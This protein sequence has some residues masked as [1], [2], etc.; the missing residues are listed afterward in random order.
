MQEIIEL[1]R[2]LIQFKTMHSQPQEIKRCAAFIEN[3]LKMLD[4]DYKRL[5]Y[6]NTPCVLV[7]PQDGFAPVLLMSHMDVVDAPGELFVPLE[8]DHRL[9]GR[10]SLDDKYAVALSLVLLKK[11]LQRL[12]KQG[13]GQ[14]D[15]PFGVLV[16]ADEEIGG[17]NG[18][19]KVLRDIQTNFCIV[20]D[21]G[22]IEKAVVKAK[23]IARVK[24]LSRAK[25]ACGARPGLGENALESLIDD[26]IRLRTYFVQSVP[27]HPDRAVV[28]NGIHADTSY[29]RVPE[30]AE[31]FLEVRYT[32]TDDME[33]L[34]DYI[35]KELHSKTVV[36]SVEPLFP[37]GESSHLNLLLGIS[38]KTKIGFEDGAND[39]R[40]LGQFGIK[41]VVWGANGDRSRH[42]LNEHVSIESV[43]ELYHLLDEFMKQS[44]ELK[45][46]K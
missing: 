29:H 36:E 12:G 15:L 35:Q 37:G 3:Y 46:A 14:Q 44:A 17:F 28:I 1:T 30:Y 27:E 34:F 24:L 39:A 40:Y 26:F 41:G 8:K 38:Q 22:S 42:S 32:E 23:G 9:Y 10:G 21:G 11:H 16:T 4:L 43:H 45:P 20:L 13:K 18:A 5:D 31:A 7:L 19:Q 6:Q 33:R 25:A 2:D